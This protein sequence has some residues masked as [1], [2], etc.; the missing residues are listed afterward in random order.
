MLRGVVLICSAAVVADPHECTLRNANTVL[1][2]PMEFG[3]PATCFM[4]TQAY[5]AGSSIGRELDASERVRII[6]EPRESVI[7]STPGQ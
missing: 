2:V 5:L 4:H 1:R 3:N 7:A 6:C